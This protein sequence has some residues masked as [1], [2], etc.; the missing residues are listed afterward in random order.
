[1]EWNRNTR[2]WSMLLMSSESGTSLLEL[3]G[4][5]AAGLVILGATLQTLSFFQ[6]TFA[7]QQGRLAQQQ[8]LRLGLELLE[9]EIRL[10]GIGSLSLMLPDAVEC[11]ANVH[12]FATNVT[13]AAAVGQ[14]TLAVDDGRGWPERKLVRVCWNEQCEQFTLARAGQRNL[15]T[16]GEPISRTIPAGASVSV[17]NRLRYY[18]HL[19]ERGSLRLLRQIDGGASVL[20][21][22][23][24]VAR[25]SYWDDRG[26]TTVQPS[27]VR[28]IVVEVSLPHRGVKEIREISL[29]S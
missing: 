11:L 17:L 4:A 13:A 21:G 6:Q 22:D 1:M 25:F 24:E 19:D 20:V 26:H 12:G 2:S 29:G 15:L 3:M 18:S 16:L 7:R 28:R 23:I 8:D 14:S 5:M 9:E 27:F 10:A